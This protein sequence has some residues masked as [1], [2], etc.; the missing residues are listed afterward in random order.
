MTHHLGMSI[1]AIC[2]ALRDDAFREY[3]HAVPEVMATDLLLHER[4]P[5]GVVPEPEEKLE[6]MP[7]H[8]AAAAD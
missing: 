2:N 5:R 1:L 6:P 8:A 7:E 4:V 3:F